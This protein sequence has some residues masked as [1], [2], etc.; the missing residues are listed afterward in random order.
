MALP[1]S[2]KRYF[3]PLVIIASTVLGSS[4][5]FEYPESQAYP[6]GDSYIHFVYATNLA[7]YGEFTYNPGVKEGIGTT[8][9]LWVVILAVFLKLGV[10]P[11]IAAKGLGIWLLVVCGILIFDLVYL[12]VPQL[13]SRARFFISLSASL[14]CTIPGN[15]IW[16]ALSGMETML[17]TALALASFSVYFREKWFLTGLFLGLTSLTRVDGI[18]LAFVLISVEILRHKRITSGL[19]KL[20]FSF[21]ILAIPWLVYLFLREG[22]PIPTSFQGKQITSGEIERMILVRNP[23]LAWFLNINPLV[24][25]LTWAGY[26]MLY[27]YGGIGLPGPQISLPGLW[28]AT[29]LQVPIFSLALFAFLIILA[30]IVLGRYLW[31][32]RIKFNITDRRHRVLFIFFVWTIIHNLAYAFFLPQPGAAGRY[33]PM[34][35]LL[36]W[37]SLLSLVVMIRIRAVRIV[38]A[39]AVA[40]LLW[41]CLRYW[42]QV[43]RANIHYLQT[44]RLPAA[45]YV[46]LNCPPNTPVGTTDLGPLRYYAHQ[47]IVDLFGYVNKEIVQLLENDGRMV[48]YILQKDIRCLY[49]FMPVDG[50]GVD[51]IKA[52]GIRDDQRFD[53]TLKKTYA[54]SLEEW[55]IGSSAVSN[56]MPSISVFR[57][58]KLEQE[59]VFHSPH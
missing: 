13:D 42:N 8:S 47:P 11:L 41:T 28:E 5:L 20:L 7:D 27:L 54:I 16:I 31:Q 43:Y 39:I 36:F 1:S 14:L 29:E 44:V 22:V 35:H 24:A 59:G 40:F 12:L 49:V 53:L 26:G 57:I 10:T 46:D 32:R 17:F 30:A 23:Q 50:S 33:A 37:M 34:N 19:V 18:A 3:L 48:D 6:M 21:L 15:T 2:F 4:A 45:Q 52:M 25:L 9:L 38:A 55:L 58:N 56:Y 51:L